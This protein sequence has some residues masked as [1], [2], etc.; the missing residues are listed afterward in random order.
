MKAMGFSVKLDTNGSQPQVLRRLLKDELLD[1]V[2]MDIKAPLN[3]YDRLAGVRTSIRR[4]EESIERVA[5]SDIA[6]TFRTTVVEPLLSPEEVRSITQ[7]VPPGSEHCLQ[8]FQPENAFDAT[9]RGDPCSSPMTP[10]ED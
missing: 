8:R 9:F 2:A 3:I 1:F 4:I 6:H 5:N 7:L 10:F